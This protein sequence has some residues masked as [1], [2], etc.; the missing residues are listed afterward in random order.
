M[1]K[2]VLEQVPVDYYDKGIKTNLFQWIWHSC[3]WHALKSLMKGMQGKILDIGCADATLTARI[4]DYLPKAQVTGLDLYK[5]SIDYAIKR[6]PEVNFVV[7][8]ARQ[9]PFKDNA[10]DLITCIET[11][12]HIPDNSRVIAEIHRVLKRG[13]NFIIVQDTDS[14]IFN[15]VW[16]LWTKWKGK[17]WNGAHVSCMKPYQIKDLL[18][19]NRFVITTEKK[20]HL[21]ME[22]FYKAIKV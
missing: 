15:I 4:A 7:A 13:G 19:L 3:K 17:V 10:F 16:M 9:I 1:N 6:H 8:D 5:K 11:L 22:V 14:F 2:K 21:G 12:E 20:S 18:L